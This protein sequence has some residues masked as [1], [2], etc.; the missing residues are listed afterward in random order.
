M[1]HTFTKEEILFRISTNSKWLYRS[2]VAMDDLQSPLERRLGRT[3]VK[4]GKG[5][6]K[7]DAEKGSMAAAKIRYGVGLYPSEIEDM[8]L[9]IQKYAS[10]LVGLANSR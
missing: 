9:R 7:Y 10:Q 6:D 3:I 8:K 2:I 1:A 4:D 5:W